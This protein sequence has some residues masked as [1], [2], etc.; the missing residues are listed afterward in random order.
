MAR[1]QKLRVWLMVAGMVGLLTPRRADAGCLFNCTYTKTRYPIVLAHGLAG[2]DKVFGAVDYFFGIPEALRDGG[3]EVYVTQ[4]SAYNTSEE[5]GEQ[6]LAQI[7]QIVATS[8]KPKVN[9]IGHSQGGLDA[10]YVAAVRPDLVASVTTVGTPNGTDPL[11]DA[12][13]SAYDSGQGFGALLQIFGPS[14][15]DLVVLVTDSDQP[16]DSIGAFRSLTTPAMAEFNARYPQGLPTTPCGQGPAVVNGIHY[17]SWGGTGVLT[18]PLDV[19]D[20]LLALFS[21]LTS[22]PNDGFVGRCSTHLGQVIRDNYLLNHFD[23][24]NQIAGLRSPFVVDPR[25][26]YRDHANRLKNA[27]L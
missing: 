23:E 1:A 12:V 24:V 3:A 10:R 21:P 27:G 8:G 2:F 16:E 26:I 9:I 4:V 6:L 19:S 25:S 14:I 13:V 11:V 22:G 17:Y 5:R 15:V 7:E 20:P 18:N